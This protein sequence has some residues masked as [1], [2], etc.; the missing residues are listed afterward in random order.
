MAEKLIWHVCDESG[1]VGFSA[2]PVTTR[3]GVVWR[4][5]GGAERSAADGQTITL[6]H[7]VVAS[8]RERQCWRDFVA[9]EGIE[10]PFPQAFR[11]HYRLE[12]TELAANTTSLFADHKIAAKPLLGAAG[13][14]GW[15][16]H[17]G[18]LA[19]PWPNGA[20][21]EFD[22]G[23]QAYPGS[24]GDGLTGCVQ[25]SRLREFRYRPNSWAE[26]DPVTVRKCCEASI[27]W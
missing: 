7:P 3:A 24:D 11:Q 10:Q 19:L 25:I 5:L 17:Y 27:S 20:G 13:S 2:V 9:N 21:F 23:T 15:V 22:I 18:M 1:Q 12:G 16:V 6:W 4:C 8:D 14:E 26:L